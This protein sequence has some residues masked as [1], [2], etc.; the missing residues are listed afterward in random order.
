MKA[1]TS[2]S[3]SRKGFTLVELLV[4]VSI[5]AILATLA[6]A[7]AKTAMEAAKKAKARAAMK[8]LADAVDLYYDRYDSLPLSDGADGDTEFRTDSELMNVLCGLE[9][10]KIENPYLTSF[11]EYK[12][13]KGKGNNQ[14]DGLART[15]T[16]AQLFGP[17]KTRNINERYY[18]VILD[19]DYDKEVREPSNLGNKI[20]YGRRYLIYSYGKDGKIGQ[21]YNIDNLYNWR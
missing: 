18:Q 21:E 1:H 11:F 5:I 15:E 12:S 13:A 8:T 6:G 9:S 10:A 16:E 3:L 20:Q 4:V 19:L 7:G 2:R 17:W 14:F